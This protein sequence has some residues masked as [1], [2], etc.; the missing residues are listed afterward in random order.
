MK[1]NEVKID[2]K[3]LKELE[4]SELV[5]QAL[6]RGKVQN[7]EWY[8]EAMKDIEKE[9][10]L[11]E[12][13]EQ[14]FEDIEPELLMGVYEPSERG[15]GFCALEEQREIALEILIAGVKKLL[16]GRHE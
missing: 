12:A 15:A 5:L 4:R 10:E 13:C 14:I 11:I 16:E 1:P 9:D 8:G 3:R 7:W 2:R 6:N